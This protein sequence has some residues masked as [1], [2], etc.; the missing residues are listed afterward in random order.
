[1]GASVL[2]LPLWPS[3]SSPLRCRR[4]SIV[5]VDFIKE[6]YLLWIP[7]APSMQLVSFNDHIRSMPGGSSLAKS[8]HHLVTQTGVSSASTASIYSAAHTLA[9]SSPASHQNRASGR[10]LAGLTSP[11]NGVTIHIPSPCINPMASAHHC[12]IQSL[13]LFTCCCFS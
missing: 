4:I 13:L 7:H 5:W 2:P 10:L 8:F 12:P 11:F 6:A 3:L 9:T 1:M